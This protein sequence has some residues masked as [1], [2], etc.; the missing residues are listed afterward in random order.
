[1]HHPNDGCQ[2]ALRDLDPED[3]TEIGK[4]AAAIMLDTARRD[5]NSAIANGKFIGI[6][7]GPRGEYHLAVQ[8]AAQIST[9]AHANHCDTQG[10]PNINKALEEFGTHVT[11]ML[12]TLCNHI[13]GTE[14]PTEA[15]LTEALN[16]TT[17]PTQNFINKVHEKDTD[18][19]HAWAEIY[20][21]TQPTERTH[22]LRAATASSLLT[23]CAARYSVLGHPTA[24]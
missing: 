15:E 16:K 12:R 10:N 7:Y 24:T 2:G 4:V 3:P 1:M 14:K 9:M 8:L 5:Y 6:H 18:A 13:A 20:G 19:L 11:D 17:P 22:L 23:V 21:T